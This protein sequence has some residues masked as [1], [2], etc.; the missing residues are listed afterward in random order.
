MHFVTLADL[1]NGQIPSG[2]IA[3]DNRFAVI[4]DDTHPKGPSRQKFLTRLPEMQRIIAE[5]ALNT[6]LRL[7]PIFNAA[8]DSCLPHPA[9]PDYANDDHV[10][11]IEKGQLMFKNLVQHYNKQPTSPNNQDLFESGMSEGYVDPDAGKDTNISYQAMNPLNF[12]V[13]T[14]F[15]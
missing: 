7:H 5:T 13:P 2:A 12:Y 3:F 14:L 8:V 6:F 10:L 11:R 9:I 1:T 15:P 4:F